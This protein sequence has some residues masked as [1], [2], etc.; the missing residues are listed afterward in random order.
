MTEEN[1]EET[2]PVDLASLTPES[3]V[4]HPDQFVLPSGE[5]I[6]YEYGSDGE[7]VGWHKEVTNG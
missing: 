5:K 1:D 3:L 6:V 7:F 2:T 4:G